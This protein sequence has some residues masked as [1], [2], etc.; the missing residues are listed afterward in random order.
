M[1]DMIRKIKE[2]RVFCS[3]AQ[4][5]RVEPFQGHRD[6]S[7]YLIDLESGSFKMSE[8]DEDILEKEK[9]LKVLQ[10][11]RAVIG[12]VKY[13]P[14]DE[15]LVECLKGAAPKIKALGVKAVLGTKFFRE[16]G[17]EEFIEHLVDTVLGASEL[18]QE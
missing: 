13:D 15:A 5:E 18:V 16:E 3:L 8:L 1:G 10:D 12:T 9:D 4:D 6:A 11:L 7:A 2:L 14:S 17:S